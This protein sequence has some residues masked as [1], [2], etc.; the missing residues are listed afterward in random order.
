MTYLTESR[1]HLRVRA[2]LRGELPSIAA[3]RYHDILIKEDL[4]KEKKSTD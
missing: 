1:T 3:V 2:F 4:W